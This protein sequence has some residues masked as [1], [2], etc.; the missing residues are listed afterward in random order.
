[1]KRYRAKIVAAAGAMLVLAACGGT[2]NSAQ[3]GANLKQ[4]IGAGEG[5]LNLI[6]WTG[7]VESGKTDPKVDWVTP[8]TTAPPGESSIIPGRPSQRPRDAGSVRAA[9]TAEGSASYRRVMRTSHST[10]QSVTE[11][12][13]DRQPPSDYAQRSPC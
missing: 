10:P 4:S 9:Q 7:Y 5:A 3:S 8:F 13:H 11:L 6:A 1:M 2:S 12:L